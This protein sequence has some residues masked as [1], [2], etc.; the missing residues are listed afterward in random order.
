MEFDIDFGTL[1]QAPEPEDDG[2]LCASIDGMVAQLSG[3]ECV[4]QVRDSDAVHVMTL[5]VLQAMNAMRTFRPLKEHIDRI[6]QQL[7]DLK[8]RRDAIGR[9]IEGLMGRG[10]VVTSDSI[11]ETATSGDER[12][13]SPTP[14]VVRTADRPEQLAKLLESLSDLAEDM[15][16]VV[17]DE[18]SDSQAG[19]ANADHVAGLT[20]RPATWLGREWRGRFAAELASSAGV[21]QAELA[22]LLDEPDTAAFTGG[23]VWNAALL[24]TAG[25][26]PVLLDD[27]MRWNLR[28]PGQV[29]PVVSF[30]Q[31]ARTPLYFAP[32]DEA[33]EPALSAAGR[34]WFA[35]HRRLCGSG[36]AALKDL[37]GFS[38]DPD[39]LRGQSYRALDR[40]TREA[41]IKSTCSGYYGDAAMDTRLWFYLAPN[42][43]SLWRDKSAYFDI[44]AHPHVAQGFG[45]VQLGEL[46]Q[47]TPTMVDNTELLPPVAPRGR[48][49][50]LMFGALV[51][52]LYP[53][54]V[55]VHL[56]SLIEHRR[57]RPHDA[58]NPD[59]FVPNASRFFAEFAL[60][61][62]DECDASAPADRMA[63]LAM[64]YRDIASASDA[65]RQTMLREFLGYMR[66]QI[67]HQL[68]AQLTGS[69]GSPDFWQQ[70]VQDWIEANGRALTESRPPRLRGWSGDLDAAGCANALRSDAQRHARWLALWPQVWSAA[71]GRFEELIGL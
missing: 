49:E 55:C 25:Q 9:V 39:T 34:D 66:S 43:A 63:L 38:I 54:S 2:P 27:D 7:P 23:Q 21:D 61:H 20:D 51:R 58:E 10:L 8:G 70:A 16:V 3:E 62:Q 64:R 19:E 40:L 47:F 71:Q 22:E 45:H 50:D 18:S 52:F 24:L 41:R 13:E 42:Q 37:E 28:E 33:L 15:P 69:S 32:G 44:M 65:R 29:R 67:V 31:S 36:L 26:R 6:E 17:I 53:H 46:S 12:A 4:F 57:V 14:I 30:R 5:D 59:A 60:A 1:N 68:Q 48:G 11:L 35:E 56:P